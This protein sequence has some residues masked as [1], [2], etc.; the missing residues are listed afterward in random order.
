MKKITILIAAWCLAFCAYGQFEKGKM[1]VGGSI[2]ADFSTNKTKY[3]GNTFT[4]GRYSSVSFDPQFGF[5]VIDNLALGAA[6]G[7]RTD[8]YNEDGSDYKTVDNEFTLQPMV[9]YYLKSRF[10]FQGNFIAGNSKSKVIDD[11]ETGDIKYNVS[12]WALAAGYAFLLNDHIA[13]EPRV[14]YGG[15]SYKNKENDVTSVDNG[16]FI[17]VGFQIYLGK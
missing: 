1:L 15:R 7:I 3:D 2:G 13:I 17:R 10:F 16:L 14:G 11:G 8:T 5:F 4:N 12:G 6:L 9:R